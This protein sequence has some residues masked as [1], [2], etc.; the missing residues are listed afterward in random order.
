MI[1]KRNQIFVTEDVTEKL[2]ELQKDN[3]DTVRF[4]SDYFNTKSFNN[5]VFR[6]QINGVKSVIV[7]HTNQERISIGFSLDGAVCLWNCA[8]AHP[9]ITFLIVTTP[10]FECD[11]KKWIKSDFFSFSINPEI[12]SYDKNLSDLFIDYDKGFDIIAHDTNGGVY[13]FD[14]KGTLMKKSE[15]GIWEGVILTKNMFDL[16]YWITY[17]KIE[18][19]ECNRVDRIT[20]KT[21]LAE[22]TIYVQ[23]FG[24]RSILTFSDG[25][26]SIVPREPMEKV[27]KCPKFLSIFS[28]HSESNQD[29]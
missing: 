3:G 12:P 16:K 26:W 6:S 27:S 15:E 18:L 21:I 5:D 1:K 4:E 11:F 17:N 2:K 8:N 28:Y 25:T 23:G 29:E 24:E 9:E 20:E 14:V 22:K 19:A 7:S 10:R 13:S